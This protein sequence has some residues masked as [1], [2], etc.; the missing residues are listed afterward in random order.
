MAH[1][2]CRPG[3]FITKHFHPFAGFKV[4]VSDSGEQVLMVTCEVEFYLWE[5]GLQAPQWWKLF[6]PEAVLLPQPSYRETC[7]DAGFFVHQVKQNK[8][9]MDLK[10]AMKY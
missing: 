10:I 5:V 4:F 3:A 1:H 2:V 9:H 7:V 8:K 6:P